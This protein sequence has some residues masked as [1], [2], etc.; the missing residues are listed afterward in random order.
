MISAKVG[1]KYG[2]LCRHLVLGK[3]KLQ[4]ISHRT[5]DPSGYNSRFMT[6]G[7][8]HLLYPNVGDSERVQSLSPR[9][10]LPQDKPWD[11]GQWRDN[12]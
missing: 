5:L 10:V 2:F 6:N 8:L 1:E 7:C 11:T 9:R 12:P 4:T 3:Y